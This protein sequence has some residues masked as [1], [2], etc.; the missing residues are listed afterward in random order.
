M[1]IKINSSGWSKWIFLFILIEICILSFLLFKDFIFKKSLQIQFAGENS[2]W[3]FK[4]P[5]L[6]NQ[7]GSEDDVI[8]YKVEDL[9]LPEKTKVSMVLTS[10]DK[11]YC[12]KIPELEQT[13]VAVPNMEFKLSFDTRKRKQLSLI[14][15]DMCGP[16][17][18]SLN[19]AII[20]EDEEKYEKWLRTKSE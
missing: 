15:G 19:R 20:I 16:D 6:D 9:H 2:N 3:I 5:G 1:T 7:F 11:L 12:L 13:E 14:A 8:I 4:Y 10:Y 17:Q 18:S